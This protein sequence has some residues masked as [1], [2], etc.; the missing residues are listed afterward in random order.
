[1]RPYILIIRQATW[2][3]IIYIF[4]PES[5]GRELENFD[6]IFLGEEEMRLSPRQRI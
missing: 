3:P 2:M 6:R 4:F 1:M 5:K